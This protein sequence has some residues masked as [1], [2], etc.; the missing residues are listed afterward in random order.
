M[1]GMTTVPY[2]R[3]K[4][5]WPSSVAWRL[6]P[7]R[8]VF[9]DVADNDAEGI[10]EQHRVGHFIAE[11]VDDVRGPA[12]TALLL[13]VAKRIEDFLELDV[14][15]IWSLPR[16]VDHD[17]FNLDVHIWGAWIE[18][19]GLKGFGLCHPCKRRALQVIGEEAERLS[20]ITLQRG[21]IAPVVE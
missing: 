18:Q 2:R 12:F 10:G 1:P 9:V 17:G 4:A 6:T 13:L 15:A 14:G 5:G 20:E 21:V 16:V 8:L 11:A 3:N 7:E 19:E